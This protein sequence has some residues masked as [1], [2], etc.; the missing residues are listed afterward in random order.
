MKT[1]AEIYRDMKQTVADG[2]GFT[3]N[4]GGDMAIRLLAA[5]HELRALW[6][7]TEYVLRQSMPQT[8]EGR[9]LEAHAQMRGLERRAAVSAQGYISFFVAAPAAEDRTIPQ[10]T[11]C[12]TDGLREFETL[13][14]GVLYAGETECTVPA[15]AT[16]AGAAGNVPAE[17]I[18]Y[19]ENAPI[20]IEGCLNRSPFL[21]GADAES[22]DELRARVLSSYRRPSNG[23]NAAFYEQQALDTPGVCAVQV[24]P[25]ARGI[26]TVDVVITGE[27]GAPSQSLLDAVQERLD[28]CREICVDVEV[29]APTAVNVSVAAEIGVKSGY[30]AQSVCEAVETAI[31]AHFGGEQ[32]GRSVLR[33]ELGSVIYAVAG[34]ENYVLS[35]PSSD[36][37]IEPDELP[38]LL[39]LSVDEIEEAEE[40]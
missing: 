9:G 15:A 11:R 7:Q 22:D 35:T 27:S 31:R 4:D 1:T 26:G 37:A 38:T 13:R 19:M 5:A 36:T 8:A 34:V 30:N 20:G 6:E 10:G 18:K 29:L 12:I 21:G 32:L 17:A 23:A 16:L 14:D 3:P 2:T 33:A 39:Y 24:L 25:R 28:E 40:E